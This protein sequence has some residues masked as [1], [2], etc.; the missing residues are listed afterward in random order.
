MSWLTWRV[1]RT[2]MI[3]AAAL[4]AVFA[5]AV[6]TLNVDDPGGM[7]AAR[8]VL[9]IGPPAFATVIAVF[10]GAPMVAREY[11]QHT[12]MLLWSRD[13]PATRWLLARVGQLLAPLVVLTLGVNLAAHVLKGNIFGTLT[14]NVAPPVDYDLWPPL[15]V[16]TVLA[17]FALGVVA[18]VLV[19]N[20]VVAMGITLV[21]YVVLRLGIGLFARPHLLP[22]DRVLDAPRPLDAISAGG[23]YLDQAGHDV[24]IVDAQDKCFSVT[25]QDVFR[26]CL[27]RNGI[28]HEYA[29]FQPASRIPDLRLVELGIYLAIAAVALA[30]AWLVLRRRMVA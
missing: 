23:G 6:L 11:E 29:D 4:V 18:G 10:W 19:R 3:S 30:A 27:A 17:G 25:S 28:A 14:S 22:P 2:T 9:L 7:N 26:Q 24:S 15:Q 16:G 8:W 5:V 20:S 13:R 12:Y 1:E 21:G